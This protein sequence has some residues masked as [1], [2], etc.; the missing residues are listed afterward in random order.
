MTPTSDHQAIRVLFEDRY[1][2][3]VAAGDRQA[4]GDL[5]TAD[6]LWI[7]PNAVPRRGPAAIGE[8]LAEMLAGH[9]ICAVFTADEIER[10]GTT[11]TVLGR[12]EAEITA[13]ADGQ[14]QHV[15]FHALWIVREQQG[16][17]RIH[18]QIW[19]PTR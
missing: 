8:G 1:P 7:R 6:A 2:A 19:T 11:A 12:S 15:S 18:R 17:W 13:D 5:Y 4:Y 3:A 10:H 16:Q 9:R 14:V